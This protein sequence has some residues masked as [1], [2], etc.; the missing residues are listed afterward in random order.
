MTS[1]SRL[2]GGGVRDELERIT[3]AVAHG[4]LTRRQFIE[5]GVALGLSVGAL[6]TVLAACGEEETAEETP[7]AWDTTLPEEIH[8]YNWSDY[9]SP[10]CLKNFEAEY[11]VKVRESYYDGNESMY[12]KLQAGA[13]GYD[14]IFPTDMWVSIL[15]KSDLIQPLDMALIPNFA[16]VTQEVFRK[17]A[18]DNPDTQDGKKYSVPYMFGTTGYAATL[19]KVPAP[20]ESW[21]Q[22]WDPAY[23]RQISML[24]AP[25]ETLGVGLIKLGYSPNTTSQEELDQAVQQCIDQKPLVL[26]YDS[27]NTRRSIVE[28]L[29]LTH[30]WDGD[31]ALAIKAIPAEDVSYVLPSE[32]YIVWADGIAIPKAAANPYAAHLFLDFMLDPK[33]VGAAAD[34]IGYQPVVTDAMQYVT[35]ETQVAMRPTDE[36]I[37][38][39]YLAEDVGD[40]QRNY[41]DAWREVVSA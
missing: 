28:G 10:E 5:R 30:C 37:E 18:F 15:R 24:N 11:G 7:Q 23:E 13:T 8:I 34:Y 20:Q 4:E 26:K 38:A 2:P 9:M 31:V 19:A 12:A 36:V 25:R 39:G 35:N 6:G 40:F 21:D 29:A 3:G 1:T 17:P 32:G 41:D 27:T 16:N 33:N 22:L 14:V